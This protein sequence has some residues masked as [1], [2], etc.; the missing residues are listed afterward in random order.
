M[1]MTDTTDK[2]APA[3]V[4]PKPKPQRKA[5]R[6]ASPAQP[7]AQKAS[8]MDGITPQDCPSAC[9]SKHCVISMRDRC[10]HPFKGGIPAGMQNDLTMRRYSEA[11]RTLGK[12]KLDLTK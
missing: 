3:P 12:Q 9:T 10:A 5:Q 6:R 8:P 1:T 11:K 7:P 2:P 4:K